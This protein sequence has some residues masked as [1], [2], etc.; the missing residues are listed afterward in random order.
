MAKLL[1]RCHTFE[2][3]D[4][5][6]QR[7]SQAATE[8]SFGLRCFPDILRIFQ[9]EKGSFQ[10]QYLWCFPKRLPAEFNTPR[11]P[12]ERDYISAASSQ[13]P[14]KTHPWLRLG[15]S[16]PRSSRV[17]TAYQPRRVQCRGPPSC[18]T[19]WISQSLRSRDSDAHFLRVRKWDPQNP[20]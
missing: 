10:I 12:G 5:K 1:A 7:P 16:P 18:Q 2:D 8:H 3:P 13:L 4:K 6:V 19:C 15:L 14:A 9:A 11:P 17:S 20:R